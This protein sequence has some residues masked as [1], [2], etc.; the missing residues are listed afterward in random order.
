[1]NAEKETI[2][3][4]VKRLGKTHSSCE[5]F[6]DGSLHLATDS[7][8]D[9]EPR[10]CQ[11]TPRIGDLADDYEFLAPNELCSRALGLLY[12]LTTKRL[13]GVSFS[14]LYRRRYPQFLFLH[15]RTALV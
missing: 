2:R 6:S 3:P 11:E 14:T 5:N 15:D 9:R 13:M 10:S 1:M 8:A 12:S 7:F 4:A